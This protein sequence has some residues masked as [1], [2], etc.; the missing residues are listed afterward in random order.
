[1]WH[2]KGH[3]DFSCEDVKELTFFT[4]KFHMTD[5][6]VECTERYCD[7]RLFIMHLLKFLILLPKCAYGWH[8]CDKKEC[9]MILL[10]FHP[11]RTG[12]SS[13]HWLNLKNV[14]LPERILMASA[15]QCKSWQAKFG[16]SATHNCRRQKSTSRIW[17]RD[18]IENQNGLYNHSSSC[19]DTFH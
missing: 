14:K 3:T 6:V 9:L 16:C 4:Q 1:M 13:L 19:G 5:H 18:S 15:F 17:W 11:L 2:N 10:L 12:N 8:Q 7:L